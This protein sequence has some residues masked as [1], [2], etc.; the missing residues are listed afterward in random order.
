MKGKLK[1]SIQGQE[2]LEKKKIIL[3]VEKEKYKNELKK[4]KEESEPAQN[5][6]KQNQNVAVRRV[7]RMADYV[8]NNKDI[9]ITINA[10]SQGLG[11]SNLVSA[12][13]VMLSITTFAF[14]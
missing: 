2:L 1:L 5:K 9:D 7:L 13:I 3:E 8:K 4:Q 11:L 14:T 10:F 6:E 12:I